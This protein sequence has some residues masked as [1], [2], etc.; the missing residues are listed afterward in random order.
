MSQPPTDPRV[1]ASA[2]LQRVADEGYVLEVRGGHLV[3]HEI[4]YV[5]SLRTIQFG[6]LVMPITFA[7]DV[8]AAPSSH[9][10][11]WV[12]DHPCHADGSL[13]AQIAHASSRHAV[14][15]D[16]FVDHSFSALPKPA[17]RYVDFHEKITAYVARISGPAE[18]LDAS[19]TP[20]TFGV[21][22]VR[23]KTSVFRY[24]EN[25][26]AL[27]GIAALTTAL[28]VSK[29]AIVGTG[30]TGAYLLDFVAKTPVEEIHLFDD[31]EFLQHNAFR[32][33]GAASL[34]ELRARPRKVE[35][36]K[37]KYD[38]MRHGLYAHAV[39]IDETNVAMLRDMHTVFVCVDSGPAR[40]L[41]VETLTGS[42]VHC[43]IV[44]M[45]IYQTPSGLAGQVATTTA[46]P[47]Q[48][49]HV[50]QRVSFGTRDEGAEDAYKQ[51]IQV[52]EL[53]ALNAIM[54]V[55][56]WKKRC[57]FF[58]DLEHEGHSAYIIEGNG[59]VNDDKQSTSL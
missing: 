44:G 15:T 32:A 56:A 24:T 55:I 5:T 41:I 7:G 40:R 1:A 13:M 46:G 57:G 14:E 39:R 3:V 36:L 12:G 16:L 29:V 33:P 20:R 19:V 47:G 9:V 52:A 59:L 10:A 42:G 35:Y 54:A 17:E 50:D 48:W 43:I 23:H 26:S 34:E 25:A 31:D 37:A 58:A 8:A 38:P 49:D 51:N 21:V 2:D 4:P 45:G 53:N 28:A 18:S 30:G 11:L 22:V 6:K 27:A